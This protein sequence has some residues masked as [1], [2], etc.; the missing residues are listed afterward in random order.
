MAHR[1]A[2]AM[3]IGN[4]YTQ[5]CCFYAVDVWCKWSFMCVFFSSLEHRDR[6]NERSKK[7]TK[8]QNTHIHF[9]GCEKKMFFLYELDTYDES[10]IHTRRWRCWSIFCWCAHTH[11]FFSFS[12]LVFF[13]HSQFARIFSISLFGL[14]FYF[15]AFGDFRRGKSLRRNKKKQF[16]V[17]SF[18]PAVH[19]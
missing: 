7:G 18:S 2:F 5:K 8:A 1:H 3:W 13:M 4:F 15:D 19:L 6:V 14:H 17:R 11:S 10:N 9:R 12:R 16:F